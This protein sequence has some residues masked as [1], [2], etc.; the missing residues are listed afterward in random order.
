MKRLILCSALLSLSLGV[1]ALAAEGGRAEIPI[2]GW[3][4]IWPSHVTPTRY[5]EARDMGLTILM[6][7]AAD[8]EDAR[9]L[10]DMAHGTGLKLMIRLHALTNEAACA[11]VAIALK[12]H[13]ALALYFVKDEPGRGWFERLGRIVGKLNAIDPDHAPY[14][15]LFGCLTGDVSLPRWCYGG[16]S[17][18]YSEYVKDFLNAV[19]VKFLSF[20]QYP[21]VFAGDATNG[22]RTA[23]TKPSWYESL[24]VCLAECKARNLPLYAFAR[25]SGNSKGTRPVPQLEHLMLQHNVN[26]AYGA[27]ML[28]YFVYWPLGASLQPG[29]FTLEWPRRRTTLFDRVRG[30]NR[31]I[32]ARAFVF[33][34]G[35][36]E[37][38]R[39]TGVDI[40]AT[41]TRLSA[42][43]LPP[44]CKSLET[45][46][47]STGATGV[48]PVAAGAVVSRIINGEREYLVIVNR[49]PT[50]ELTLK[51][52][53]DEGVKRIRDDGTIVDATLYIGEYELEPGAMEV[54]QRP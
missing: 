14:V 42:N 41:T 19:P 49:S 52:A 8:V 43:D 50:S 38:V 46:F 6:Q 27:Q 53:F 35:K 22:T 11:D 23:M 36:V 44:W 25:S 45:E 15:N 4:G 32:Q 39:H 26:L 5:A 20:D 3:T 34:G 31:R 24:E 21:V 51:I 1:S 12:N 7:R 13:P 16:D 37:R 30:A 17:D 47:P 54:F 2:L 48:S 29:P 33:L 10:L 28:Q 9:R 18:V 40:P